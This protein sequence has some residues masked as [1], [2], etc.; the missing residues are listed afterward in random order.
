MEENKNEEALS[1]C[2]SLKKYGH[3]TKNC[4]FL[5]SNSSPDSASTLTLNANAREPIFMD[6][7]TPSS[8]SEA[9][10]IKPETTSSHNETI[11]SAVNTGNPKIKEMA[12]HLDAMVD[13]WTTKLDPGLGE[14][15]A[16][17]P[18]Q[19]K[20]KDEE[21]KDVENIKEEPMDN[22][23]NY[24]GMAALT[25]QVEVKDHLL[26]NDMANMVMTKFDSLMKESDK[27]DD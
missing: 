9:S 20:I 18:E 5:F 19:T 6:M 7:D 10:T 16:L 15:H 27:S 17:E 3:D 11:N 21:K 25:P 4:N 1:L 12:S 26:R 24:T 14:G 22:M 2:L 13:D 23:V 8:I